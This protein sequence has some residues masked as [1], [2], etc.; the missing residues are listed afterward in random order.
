MLD[1]AVKPAIKN[2]ERV[3]RRKIDLQLAENLHKN[4][5]AGR[6]LAGR[7]LQHVD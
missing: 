5:L 4:P 3:G 6:L 1:D 7:G 2:T